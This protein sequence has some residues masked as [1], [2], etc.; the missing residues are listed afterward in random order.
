MRTIDITL[1]VLGTATAVGAFFL[2][3]KIESALFC[4]SFFAVGL[5]GVLFPP[6]IIAWA[7]FSHPDLDPS[8]QSI[9]WV[10][11]LVGSGLILMALIFTY[12]LLS[13]DFVSA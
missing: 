1:R 3:N 8:D 13:K 11:R 12:M 2:P 7:K 5:W 9:W 10:S 4:L 6:G